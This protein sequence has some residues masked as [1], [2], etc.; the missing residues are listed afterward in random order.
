[1][2]RP[3]SGVRVGVA[4]PGAGGGARMGGVRKP[5]L[6]LAGQPVLRLAI[7]PFLAEPRVVA[8]AVALAPEEAAEPPRWLTVLDTRVRVVE[9]G[10]TRTESVRRAIAALPVDVD[11]IAVHD[12]ARPLVEE[13]VVAECIDLA[14]TGIGAVAGCPATD[15]LK[16]VDGEARVR[17]TPDRGTLWHA[18]TPQVFPAALL[19]DAYGRAGAE[20]TD[21]AALVEAVGGEVRM[22]DGG[23]TNLKITRPEDL[24]VAEAILRLRAEGA[25]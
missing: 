12:A 20:S 10:A 15:T 1:M 11:V 4:V 14:A 17:A 3:S 22:V 5:F 21:D 13:R 23:R 6:E 9:G 24:A 7:Q 2:S 16:W 18:H 19:R 25:R 8:V